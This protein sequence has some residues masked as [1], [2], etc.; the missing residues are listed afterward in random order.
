MSTILILLGGL[1]II[2]KLT[3]VIAWSWFLVLL[4]ILIAL[5]LLVVALIL[6]F[7]VTLNAVKIIKKRWLVHQKRF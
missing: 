7:V 5:F 1:F 4:P 6:N 3:G 2:L